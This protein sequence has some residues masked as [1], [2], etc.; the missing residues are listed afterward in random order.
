MAKAGASHNSDNAVGYRPAQAPPRRPI[1]QINGMATEPD[2]DDTS[3]IHDL[4]ARLRQ[5]EREI[6]LLRETTGAVGSE[7]DLDKVF[8]LIVDRVRELI[9]SQTVLLPLLNRDCDEYTYRAGSGANIEEIVGASLPL[10]FGVCGWVWQHK[11]A[12][13]RGVL[14]ELPEREK[15]LW[16]KDAGTLLL[17]PLIGRQ[18]FLGGI[19]C[20]NKADGGEYTES[21]LHLLELFAGQAA[22]AI[23]NAMAMERVN[24]AMHEAEEAHLELQRVNKRL[25]AVN[26]ELEYLSLYDHLTGL[27]NRSLFRDRMRMEIAGRVAGQT[28]MALLIADLDRFQ[29]I[30]DSLGHEAGDE[31]LRTV[32]E[33]FSAVLSPSG[34][35]SRM[36]G[37]EFA[38]LLDHADE[39]LALE[40]AR[41][42]LASLERPIPLAG[43]ELV[44]SAS[45]GIALCPRHGEEI[46]DLF[47]HADTALLT[48]KRENCGVHVYDEQRD[49]TGPGRY[50]LA[51]ELRT[52]LDED[53]FELHYQPKLDLVTNTIT[54]VEALARWPRKD[55]SWV[56][57]DMFISALEQTGLIQRFTWWVIETAVRQRQDWLGKGLDLRIAV[58]VPISMIT[59][60]G[61]IPELSTLFSRHAMQ[62]GLTMEITENAFFG[63]YE[64]LNTVLTEL[65]R[66]DIDCSID[67]FGTGHSSLS[68]L[69]K[70][71]VGELK[72]DRSFVMDMLR[73]KDDAVIVKSTIDLAQNLGLKVVAEGV[74]NAQTLQQLYRLRC[75]TV[76]GFYIARALPVH[77]LERFLA[78]SKW[79]VARVEPMAS[80][81]AGQSQA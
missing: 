64:H 60:P 73:S 52:A 81:D 37:D 80:D 5:R 70:L 27:P 76:Q 32:A 78:A 10:D 2:R 51:R 62:C 19:A 54:A 55:G 45:V 7:L 43:Q 65:R 68:R 41:A 9:P 50:A 31:L 71:P 57:P 69:R 35:L 17:V 53:E 39:A 47:K 20:I 61:F 44:V 34:T 26:Q 56:P 79:S 21:D 29:E 8:A 30:N 16:E 72:I 15:N 74:E 49:D 66:F 67:D 36:S 24:Q 46:S 42:M 1:I 22:I 77:E 4:Q 59:D 40:T 48:A 28:G 75:D 3:D 23:E 63:D 13:W 38:L 18:H 58:N 12:W 33:R 25:S 11:R 14:S 6:A